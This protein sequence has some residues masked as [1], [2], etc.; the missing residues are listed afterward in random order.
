MSTDT[1]TYRA[2]VEW[3]GSTAS[4]YTGYDRAH[5]V[6]CFPAM[7]ELDVSSDPA[8]EGN[9]ALLNPEQL[10]LAAASS[11]Q[12]L[13]FLAV[14]AR[15]RIDVVEYRDQASAAMPTDDRPV[16]I[17]TI[18]LRP[19]ITVRG[20]HGD[21]PGEERLRHLVGVAHRECFIANTLRS[22]ITIVPTFRRAP[23]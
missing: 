9:P 18:T 11:C 17:T 2:T 21:E 4:G 10:L 13:S 7:A 22:E 20:M 12:L 8:F 19:S 23:A 5:H 1:H 16:R 6:T 3:A 15:A 14:A